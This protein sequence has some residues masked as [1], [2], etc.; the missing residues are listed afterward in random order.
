MSATLRASLQAANPST[1]WDLLRYLG[2]GDLVR[3]SMTQQLRAK[4]GKVSKSCHSTLDALGVDSSARGATILRAYARGGSNAGELVVAAYG[5]TPVSGQ[6]SVAPNGDI[7]VL[8]A[9]TLTKID[10]DYM[11]M[12]GDYLQIPALGVA[13]NLALLP[14]AV[15][16][17]GVLMLISGQS[18][19]G[20]NTGNFEVLKANTSVVAGQVALDV[21]K[22]N[23][24]FAAAD[25][26]TS[27]SCELLLC[28]SKDVDTLLKAQSIAI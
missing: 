10:V 6:I 22:S 16:T 15:T 25:A 17:Q 9:D 19:A 24:V 21:T 12:K 14:S 18:L 28:S 27:C 3:Q 26:V 7:V 13:S 2:L 23:I 5:A 20:T 1:A 11:P 8:T 4:T